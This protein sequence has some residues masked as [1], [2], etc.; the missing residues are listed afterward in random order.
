MNHFE[1]LQKL[2]DKRRVC[3]GRNLSQ[4]SFQLSLTFKN[5]MNDHLIIMAS[6]CSGN[7]VFNC[8]IRHGVSLFVISPT[9]TPAN[10]IITQ[11]PFQYCSFLKRVK[12]PKQ[13]CQKIIIWRIRNNLEV[14]DLRFNNY[15]QL[16]YNSN[17][18]LTSLY[19]KM[20][21]IS[22]CASILHLI[23]IIH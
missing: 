4:Y 12:I 8:I 7:K 23:N 18:K 10:N 2:K 9:E 5:K 20:R 19:A 17:V 22:N 13:W 21:F 11:F 1:I 15:L 16:C 14:W 3:R 6:P